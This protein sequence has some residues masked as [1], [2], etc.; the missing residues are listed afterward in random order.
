MST[1]TS[2]NQ[3][4]EYSQTVSFDKTVQTF[5]ATDNSHTKTSGVYKTTDP[6]AKSPTID[7]IRLCVPLKKAFI[8][9]HW[10]PHYLK[11]K[12]LAFKPL[13]NPIQEEI[14]PVLEAPK[15]ISATSANISTIH[16]REILSKKNVSEQKRTKLP[17]A[18]N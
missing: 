17:N 16:E 14:E 9:E 6:K 10:V 18:K 4:D 1:Q 7:N 2:L 8:R 12:R 3:L 5:V 11:K 15:N 13:L